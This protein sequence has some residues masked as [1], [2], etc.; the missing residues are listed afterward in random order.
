M[1]FLQYKN[2]KNINKQNFLQW[3]AKAQEST[4]T[5]LTLSNY[6]NYVH[7]KVELPTP[8]SSFF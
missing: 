6:N 8:H 3:T 2:D 1:S 5:H 7:E 4:K